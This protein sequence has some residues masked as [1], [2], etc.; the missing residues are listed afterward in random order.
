MPK[1]KNHQ[2]DDVTKCPFG[3]NYF[4]HY[5]YNQIILERYM[6]GRDYMNNSLSD[7]RDCISKSKT[8]YQDH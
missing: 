6:L 2:W 8:D 4:S 5:N 1:F 3:K 7:C